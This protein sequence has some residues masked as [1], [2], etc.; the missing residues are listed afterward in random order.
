MILETMQRSANYEKLK[1]LMVT[2][3]GYLQAESLYEM[4]RDT[5]DEEE[6]MQMVIRKMT[7]PDCIFEGYEEWDEKE[8]KKWILTFRI[9]DEYERYPDY[10]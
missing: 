1:S 2:S 5:F 8:D 10:N 3:E 7:N 6:Q 9:L 4:L